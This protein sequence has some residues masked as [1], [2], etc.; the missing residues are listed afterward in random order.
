[1]YLYLYDHFLNAP[2]YNKILA[3]IEARLTDLGIGGKISRLSPLKDIQELIK[4]EV[5][6]GVNTVVVVGNDTTVTQIINELVDL[7]ITL[8]IIPIGP[9]NSIAELLGIPNAEDACDI[10]SA[11]RI[12]RLDLGKINN[13]YFL[14]NI[15]VS[16]GKVTLECDHKYHI[17]P[18]DENHEIFICNLR[19][20]FITHTPKNQFNPS[21]GYLEALIKPSDGMSGS[22]FGFLKSKAGKSS[23]FPIKKI[24]ISGNGSL[25]VVT[26]GQKI[27]KTPVKIEVVPAKLKFI[28]G[29]KRAFR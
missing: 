16:S 20:A 13:V 29:K 18:N 9:R 15:T 21:D 12:A 6:G 27:L 24:S 1:M 28:V 26:D 5:Y 11:R 8:G 14:S 4:D 19:P 2:K 17:T 10:L 23:V 22:I 25:T 7:Q 3:N